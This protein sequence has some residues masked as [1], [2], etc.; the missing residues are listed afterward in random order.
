M[1][2][3]GRSIHLE[4]QV[5]KRDLNV[6]VFPIL[7]FDLSTTHIDPDISSLQV[8]LQSSRSTLLDLIENKNRDAM[9]EGIFLLILR[10]Q[11][12]LLQAVYLI[13]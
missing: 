3:M 5:L 4:Y 2:D 6:I 8:F 1:L 10:K 11:L 7:Q 12:I 9:Q 13:C